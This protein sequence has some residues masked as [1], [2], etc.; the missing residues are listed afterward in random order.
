MYEEFF[1][2]KETPFS[3]QPDP[4]FAFPSAEHKIAVAKM[5]YAA[6]GKRGLAVLTGAVGMGKT[7]VANQLQ[8]NLGR[9]S[10][11]DGSLPA[12]VNSPHARTIPP[13]DAERLWPA[14]QTHRGG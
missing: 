6:D 1:G 13:A 3:V 8:I 14:I 12:V 9:R 4:R 2:L 11:Q 7:T 5:R 10:H